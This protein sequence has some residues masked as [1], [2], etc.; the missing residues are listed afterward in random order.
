MVAALRES[1]FLGYNMFIENLVDEVDLKFVYT[2]IRVSFIDDCP[3]ACYVS[4]LLLP[5]DDRSVASSIM[6]YRA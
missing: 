1:R 3:I 6:S 2:L 5:H 4:I